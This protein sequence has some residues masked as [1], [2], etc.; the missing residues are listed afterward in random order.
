MGLF[1]G[2]S[3]VK[4]KPGAESVALVKAAHAQN[5]KKVGNVYSN[6]HHR[7]L[8]INRGSKKVDDE[9]LSLAKNEAHSMGADTLVAIT[10]TEGGE[11]KFIA[12]KC[13]K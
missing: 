7:V 4:V 9:L 8:F 11:Q 3:W 12:Y 2:C 10:G 1:A 6:T 13:E 5:C